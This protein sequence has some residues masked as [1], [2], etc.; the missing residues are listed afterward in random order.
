MTNQT[1]PPHQVHPGI[2]LVLVVAADGHVVV[3]A[4]AVVAAASVGEV[5]VELDTEEEGDV[6][7]DLDFAQD[8]DLGGDFVQ[9]ADWVAL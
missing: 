5:A 4:V 6:P 7:L 2:F 8:L 1:P 9:I 3:A